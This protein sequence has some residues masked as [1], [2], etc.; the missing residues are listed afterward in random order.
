MR[1]NL[2]MHGIKS[3]SVLGVLKFVSKYEDRQV[4]G[5]SIP[6]VM[7]SN[8]VMETKAYKTYL[9]FATGNVIPKKAR[10][11][12]MAHITP[13]KESSLTADDNIIPD[14]PDAALEL[15]KSISK[16]EAKE[17]EASRLVHENHECLVTEQTTGRRR[18]TGVTIRDTPVVS[19][20]KT[21]TYSKL[22]VPDEPKGKSRDTSEGAGSKLEVLD[23]SKAKSSD[24]ESENVEYLNTYSMEFI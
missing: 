7:L 23:V 9:A 17:Q 2:F 8:E 14:D 10:K 24:Q 20:K 19:T 16:T 12:T 6:D 11:R 22:E 13:L 5:K 21:P 15:A 3:D 4:Y 18:Q 1:N